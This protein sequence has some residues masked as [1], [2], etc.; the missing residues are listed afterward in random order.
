M[1]GYKVDH[2]DNHFGN[3]FEMTVAPCD[4]SESLSVSP[5]LEKHPDI[6]E[7]IVAQVNR[8]PLMTIISSL[9]SPKSS[10]NLLMLLL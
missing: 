9:L 2:R 8:N 1:I 4:Y 6:A 3:K 7:K 5:Y 10:A